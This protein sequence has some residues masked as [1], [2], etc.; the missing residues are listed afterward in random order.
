MAGERN[1]GLFDNS[2]MCMGVASSTGAQE[3]VLPV[4]KHPQ[5]RLIL[6]Q[7]LSNATHY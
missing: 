6:P 2:L 3:E 1:D 4:E 5:K 7:K